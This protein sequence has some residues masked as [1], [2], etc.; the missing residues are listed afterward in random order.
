MFVS[1]NTNNKSKRYLPTINHGPQ[2]TEYQPRP[3]GYIKGKT[4]KGTIQGPVQSKLDFGLGYKPE[5]KVALWWNLDRNY[6]PKKHDVSAP[7]GK[8]FFFPKYFV[9]DRAQMLT[10]P[11]VHRNWLAVKRVVKAQPGYL[12]ADKLFTRR[13][14]EGALQSRWT[15]E[16]YEDKKDQFGIGL[17]TGVPVKKFAKGTHK[18]QYGRIDYSRTSDNELDVF[19]KKFQTEEGAPAPEDV[20]NFPHD[21]VSTPSIHSSTSSEGEKR[22]KVMEFIDGAKKVEEDAGVT[23]I[24]Q[25]KEWFAIPSAMDYRPGYGDLLR[26]PK[27]SNKEDPPVSTCMGCIVEHYLIPCI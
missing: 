3:K 10:T 13:S 27:K 9:H 12:N 5:S 2:Q 1:K 14:D 7:Q 22:K 8:K 17:K 18:L 25:G 6:D 23:K 26:K 16:R 11:L 21:D 24:S 20:G 4:K 19:H 15:K